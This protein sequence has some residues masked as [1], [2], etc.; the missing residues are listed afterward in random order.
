LTRSLWL[1]DPVG[2]NAPGPL[3]ILAVQHGAGAFGA[4]HRG[5]APAAL[6]DEALPTRGVGPTVDGADAVAVDASDGGGG[7][8]RGH[9]DTLT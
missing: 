5:D 7:G 2:N 3:A 6:A 8:G 4:R 9:V 1:A